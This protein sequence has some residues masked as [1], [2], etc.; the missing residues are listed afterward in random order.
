MAFTEN[1]LEQIR[2]RTH[3]SE[4]VSRRVRLIR[5]GRGE[6]SGLCPFHDEKTPSF[7]VNDIKGFYHCFG[8]GAHGSIFDFVMKTDGLE[9]PEAVEILAAEAGLQI[10]KKDENFHEKENRLQ[11][12][13]LLNLLKAA[14]QW[15]RGQMNDRDGSLA[16]G[17]IKDR[18]ILPATAEH[19]S[20][21]FAPSARNQLKKAMIKIGFSEKELILVGLIIQ[22]E[23]GRES[24]DRFRNRLIF[25]ITDKRGRPV[26]FGGR[27]LSES[28]AK[29]LNSPETNFFHKGSLLYNLNGAREEIKNLGSLIVV[30][31]YTDVISLWQAGIKNVVAPLGTA[32]TDTQMMELW[33]LT[34]EPVL[35]LDGDSAGI[36]AAIRAAENALPLLKPNQS[37]R[38]SF[39]P[40][41]EDPDSIIQKKGIEGFHKYFENPLPLSEVLWRSAFVGDFSTPERQAGLRQTLY[42][43]VGR[44]KDKSVQK[45]YQRYFNVKLEEAFGNDFGQDGKKNLFKGRNVSRISPRH[46][47]SLSDGLGY[48]GGGLARNRERVLV[49]TVLN[50]PEILV[51]L[52]ETAASVQF[53]SEDLDRLYSRIIDIVGKG[54]PLDREILK[55]QL[56]KSGE[57][58]MVVQL[59]GTN[60]G[61]VEHFIKAEAT[62]EEAVIGWLDTLSM[63]MRGAIKAD[64]LAAVK[65]LAD[66]GSD[67]AFEQL[68]A[69]KEIEAESLS[70]LEDN[71]TYRK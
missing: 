26:G 55:E 6:H 20:I 57:E 54:K 28:S 2:S 35:S 25:P 5:K 15:F 8:C 39:L 27:A 42:S 44:M 30:E 45:Y 23:D 53:E 70:R 71:D 36:R 68:K 59:T 21:G 63:H 40:S 10:P 52:I 18:G 41:G 11:R 34:S 62:Q 49:A 61:L 64:C 47:L 48:G 38:F 69:L 46:K 12:E 3:I 56:K 58:S 24:Y 65:R 29:Y 37:L 16:L 14:M 22:P 31:G 1:F 4:I 33:R 9:F 66:E 67:T 17:Y 43:L 19:F 32:L 7:T 60:S 13:R 51:D 50:H